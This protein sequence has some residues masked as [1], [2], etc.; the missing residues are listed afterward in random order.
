M[1]EA[2]T[3]LSGFA[4]AFN[5]ARART[6]EQKADQENL[7]FKYKMDNLMEQKTK[8]DAKKAKETEAAKKAQDLAGQM[9]DPNS[10]SIFYKELSNGVDYETL[11]KRVVSGDYQKNPNYKEPT[12]TIKM[13]NAVTNVQYDTDV[14]PMAPK[15]GDN[16]LAKGAKVQYQGMMK[17]VNDKID[18]IDPTLR[19]GPADEDQFSTTADDAN[20]LYTYK[21]KDT[22][23]IGDYADSLNKLRIAQE[24]KDPKAIR[25]AQEEVKIQQRVRSETA[26]DQAHA[27]GKDASTYFS[28]NS[29]GS[30]GSQFTGE[31][32]ADGIY[33][34]SGNEPQL[35]SGPVRRMEPE[36]VQRFNKL[37]DDYGKQS[38]D[39]NGASTNFISAL[40]SSQKMVEIL[41]HDRTAAT[42]ASNLAGV[43]QNL[44]GEA[45]SAFEVLANLETKINADVQS[46]KL[47]SIEKDMAAYGEE[48]KKFVDSGFM[49]AANQQKA[50]NAA[51]YR[52]LQM[53]TAYAIAQ[54]NAT[55]GKV[56]K[57]DID[58]AMQIIG[59]SVD[60]DIIIPT[61]N[62]QMQGAF[63]KLA[64]GQRQLEQN[65]AVIN[66]EKLTGVKTGLRPTRI[67]D[68]ID[69]LPGMPPER[70]ALLKQ[71][72][73]NI[74]NDF[75]KGQELTKITGNTPPPQ[76]DQAP[77]AVKSKEEFD[78]LPS[79]AIFIDPNGNKRRKP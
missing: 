78:K 43:A 5:A 32:R 66:F 21:P 67:G 3:F 12:R 79:G 73:N 52:S 42:T 57:N 60:A 9:G 33:N 71:Y 24:S 11:Q 18:S 53:S 56:S 37:N 23:K 2:Q 69:Q 77:I 29:D 38:G 45:R 59:K 65:P 70:K 72:L 4:S 35:V 44:Q 28:L 13:P 34:I 68:Q 46:G 1:A 74:N 50:L 58:N 17:S 55:D 47:D 15:E 27:N 61:L 31:R 75:Q 26:L 20:S 19:S 16:L 30:I 22:Y 63:L 14:N 39:W 41:G 62:Q 36:D 49:G 7:I 25:E 54:A 48:A 64:S 51:K 6:E 10:A 40:D 8:R 76:T